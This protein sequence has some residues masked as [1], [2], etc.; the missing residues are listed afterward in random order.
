MRDGLATPHEVAA[1]L[2]ISYQTVQS[3][4]Q[5]AGIYTAQS[6]V[7]HVKRLLHR[8]PRVVPVIADVDPDVPF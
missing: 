8:K 5:R 3:W 4:R 6:R 1:A 2:G 7:E